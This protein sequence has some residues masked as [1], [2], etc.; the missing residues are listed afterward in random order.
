[1]AGVEAEPRPERAHLTALGSD[2]PQ[3]PILA[4]RPVAAEVPIVERAGAL[5]D[6]PVEAPD[7]IDEGCGSSAPSVL[8][9]VPAPALALAAVDIL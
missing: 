4:E 8:A 6:D 5:G 3:D 7:L 2:L 1:M 9:S